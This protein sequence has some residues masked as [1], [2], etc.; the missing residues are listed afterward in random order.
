MYKKGGQFRARSGGNFDIFL[1][2][3]RWLTWQKWDGEGE[4]GLLRSITRNN[5]A[6][7]F[8]AGKRRLRLIISNS[9][10]QITRLARANDTREVR[11]MSQY[12][13]S[14]CS[15]FAF[16]VTYTPPYIFFENCALRGWKWSRHF[17]FHT[18]FIARKRDTCAINGARYFIRPES[19]H[20]KREPERNAIYRNR[21][22]P[23]LYTRKI[24]EKDKSFFFFFF[25]FLRLQSR[26][27][28]G[29]MKAQ[30]EWANRTS[31]MKVGGRHW[32]SRY[33]NYVNR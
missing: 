19:R 9:I 14:A 27:V 7:V 25:V 31:G 17:R 29:R 32:I 22:A 21:I 8:K 23:V 11:A 28:K 26:E 15:Y 5:F 18:F 30:S 3:F 16:L 20:L 1:S 24:G 4:R 10:M 33:W 13:I 2:F 12:S 6:T